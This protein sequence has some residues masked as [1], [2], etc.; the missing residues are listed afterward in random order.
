M[1]KRFTYDD[2]L[3]RLAVT[4]L[5]CPG[6]CPGKCT[7]KC[8]GR[9][10][11]LCIGLCICFIGGC[12]AKQ[13]GPPPT[14]PPPSVSVAL[15]VEKEIVEW[16]T[17]TGRLE[18][19]NLVEV[20]SR[21]GGYLDSVHFEEGQF[22]N[23]E[24]LLFIVDPRPFEAEVRMA[25]AAIEEAEARFEQSKAQLAQARAS[26]ESM[27]A[28]IEY[29]RTQYNRYK[30]L[31]ARNAASESDLE[32]A[33][34]VFLKAQA[35]VESADASIAL[36]NAS[37]ATAAASI[38]TSKAAKNEAALNLE[39][40]NIKAPISGRIS[41][42]YVTEGNL[43]S[44]GS[45]QSTLLTTIVSLDPIY[46]V[47]D[48]SEQQVLRLQRLSQGGVRVSARDAR[49]PVFLS[50]ADEDSF[51]RRGYIDFV[52]NRFDEGTAT[53]TARAEFSNKDHFLT[54]GMFGKLQ[55]AKTKP[56]KTLLVPD[57]A[58]GTDQTEQFVYV[59]SEDNQAIRK[60]VETG[61]LALGL[62]VIRN[63]IEPTDRVVVV[64][65]QR[66]RLGMPLDPEPVTIEAEEDP[67]TGGDV[68]P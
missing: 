24:D 44:G 13:T 62:R 57:S 7:G 1:K 67:F 16:D 35:G 18:A 2:I 40:T 63:G 61:P 68:A 60:V 11:V 53:M 8:P 6:K 28:E 58:I 3:A 30:E 27:L 29:A 15:P 66:V 42:R 65:L 36:A 26:K 39:Y 14:P 54:P 45:Q 5:R 19:V 37:I 51:S 50:L 9:C 55:I 12:Q 64:G 46:F 23:E 52:D 17:F 20:R 25:E 41:R 47:F 31:N 49:Y 22:V 4:R 34:S 33:R 32:Q 21:V 38:A 56:F 59:L 48:A 43:I 10:I